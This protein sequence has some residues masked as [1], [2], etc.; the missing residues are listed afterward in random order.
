M[1]VM[2]ILGIEAPPQKEKKSPYTKKI[3][4]LGEIACGQPRFANQEYD[5]YVEVGHG[6]KAD[7]AL[8]ARGDSMIDAKINDGDIIF[9]TSQNTVNNGEI[10]VIIIDDEATLKR[11]YF[12]KVKKRLVLQPENKKY[13]PMVHVGEELENIRII[14][15]AVVLKLN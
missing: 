7:F 6:I 15:K 3:P 4:M 14:G 9:C 12:D 5:E 8:T 11:I 10:G 2:D 1:D 13:E